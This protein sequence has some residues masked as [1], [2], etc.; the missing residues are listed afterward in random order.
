MNQGDLLG[1]ER[2]GGRA[3]AVRSTGRRPHAAALPLLG[4]GGAHAWRLDDDPAS[5][6]ETVDAD[7]LGAFDKARRTARRSARGRGPSR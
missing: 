6:L 3:G 7:D 1:N 2:P 4:A 5:D